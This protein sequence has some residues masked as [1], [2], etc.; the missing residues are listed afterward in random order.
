MDIPIQLFNIAASENFWGLI[1]ILVL[2]VLLIYLGFGIVVIRQA[3][4]MTRT[5]TG[6]LDKQVRIISWGIFVF[7]GIVFLVTAIFL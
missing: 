4:L 1:K 2:F 3:Q 7:T 6:K 5:V